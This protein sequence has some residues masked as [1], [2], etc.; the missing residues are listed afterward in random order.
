MTI[1]L[2]YYT[3]T[4]WT[5]GDISA[6]YLS[7]VRKEEEEEEDGWVCRNILCR[8][9]SR[10]DRSE[11]VFS[12]SP[13]NIPSPESERM[14]RDEEGREERKGSW[15]S[16]VQQQKEEDKPTL[17]LK[18]CQL[19]QWGH[20][21]HKMTRKQQKQSSQ[22]SS[23]SMYIIHRRRHYIL[24]VCTERE[25]WDKQMYRPVSKVVEWY[26]AVFVRSCS[27]SPIQKLSE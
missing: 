9:L 18:V 21:L 13:A 23:H 6:S 10:C 4:W 20:A 12:G 1:T 24:Y 17:V 3:H 8:Q 26:K 14:R 7:L 25:W 15:V 16:G 19:Q 2:L 5:N 27:C 11:L 22:L